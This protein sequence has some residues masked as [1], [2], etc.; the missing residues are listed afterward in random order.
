MEIHFDPDLDW[1]WV[2]L[3]GQLAP[4]VDVAVARELARQ[5]RDSG[6]SLE[7]MAATMDVL[8]GQVEDALGGRLGL[9]FRLHVRELGAVVPGL[10][11]LAGRQSDAL[12]SLALNVEQSVYSML[13]EIVYFANSVVWAL[14]NP[15]TAPLVPAFITAARVAVAQVVDRLNWAVRLLVAAVREGVDEVVQGA[16][17]QLAQIAEGTR[18]YWD[19][20]SSLIEFTA[21]AAA[22][23]LIAGA[24]LGMSRVAPGF[25]K[26]VVF[27]ALN[28]AAAETVV[29]AGAAGI[30]G[31]SFDDLWA[32]AVNGAF[33]SS[34][35]RGAH[36]AGPKIAAVAAGIAALA[37]G[38]GGGIG[39]PD[40]PELPGGSGEKGFPGG[41]GPGF[42]GGG[43][44]A[45]I[46]GGGGGGAAPVRGP[47]VGPGP[48]NGGSGGGR[49]ASGGFGGAAEGLGAAGQGAAG[50]STPVQGTPGQ[51]QAGQGQTGQGVQGQGVQGQ[52]V[53]GQGPPTQGLAGLAPRSGEQFV[54]DRFAE[55]LTADTTAPVNGVTRP[56]TTAA[57]PGLTGTGISDSTPGIRALEV[58]P[59]GQTP[60]VTATTDSTGTFPGVRLPADAGV[61]SS[62]VDGSGVS[63]GQSAPEPS[64]TPAGAVVEPQA[65]EVVNI[66]TPPPVVEDRTGDLQ[67]RQDFDVRVG[68]LPRLGEVP[69]GV[70][71][72][73]AEVAVEIGRHLAGK[74]DDS[75]RNI[76]HELRL[77]GVRLRRP[78]LRD[79]VEEVRLAR[80]GKL[81]PTAMQ[82]VALG[83]AGMRAFP[84]PAGGDNIYEAVLRSR[85]VL[86]ERFPTALHLRAA[87]ADA[88]QRHADEFS[89]YY[90]GDDYAAEVEYIRQRGNYARDAGNLVPRGIAR[91][92]G[93]SLQ[94]MGE[95]GPGEGSK[96]FDPLSVDTVVL[97]RRETDGGH[98]L[99]SA[100]VSVV[101]LGEFADGRGPVGSQ[102]P[103]GEQEAAGEWGVPWLDPA[104]DA[105][106]AWQKLSLRVT[107]GPLAEATEILR[108]ITRPPAYLAPETDQ[109]E[110]QWQLD[111]RVVEMLAYRIHQQEL[112]MPPGAGLLE[113]AL[114]LTAKAGLRRPGGLGGKGTSGR[115]GSTPPEFASG[116][117]SA[118]SPSP[119][120]HIDPGEDGQF[121]YVEEEPEG[122]AGIDFSV[123]GDGG[124]SFP[125]DVQPADVQ[126]VD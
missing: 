90:D 44:G 48:G 43:G 102:E 65:R 66:S 62:S 5:W 74:P 28:E 17:A 64:R 76:V 92:A 4:R 53:Q 10:A 46:P 104:V 19:K 8:A 119:A 121:R 12:L 22:G 113:L 118:G 59:T 1:L 125:A 84:V 71:M 63:D 31:G 18:V 56:D 38:K 57:G 95:G 116:S 49:G 45:G 30:L 107:E 122:W 89:S 50:Q 86:R 70:A 126:M 7:Q 23:G 68:E 29:G 82:R 32:G 42:P 97:P 110:S 77:K 2:L 78:L 51:V 80:P 54:G 60:L 115:G 87:T 55:A 37:A 91:A 106:T 40:G 72:P 36:D 14:S 114:E 3:A 100:D 109:V 35:E 9:V 26:S 34:V 39:G 73:A 21:G 75:V 81:V 98:Y 41:G 112:G 20:V 15:F 13:I 120:F 52:G 105:P 25:A 85:P 33:S 124:P 79:L 123:L 61:P 69:G 11:G 103:A 16:L 83:N 6:V 88:L 117:E 94:I 67:Q 111:Q 93:I 99:G 96:T 24:A 47:G 101:G 58:S 108:G 27:G